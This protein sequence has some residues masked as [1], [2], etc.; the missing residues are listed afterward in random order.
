MRGASCRSRRAPSPRS[1]ARVS[2]ARCGS[3]SPTTTPSLPRRHPDPLL[4]RPSAGGDLGRLRE[5]GR[6]RRAQVHAGALDLALVTDDEGLRELRTDPRGAVALDRLAAL[7]VPEGEPIPLALG[8]PACIWRRVAEEALGAGG[9]VAACSSRRTTPRSLTVVRAGLAA[10]VLPVS[11]IGEG[12]RVLGPAGACRPCR[13]PHG[14]HLRARRARQRRLVRS[15]KR[16]GRRSAKCAGR[17]EGGGGS[18]RS[19]RKSVASGTI[20]AQHKGR[21]TERLRRRGVHSP[22]CRLS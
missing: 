19:T 21:W 17:R 13:S 12:L 5:F 20:V 3:A 7:Q 16:C 9:N 18:S 10:T 15:R 14:P 2:G 11:M 8:S 6:A 4:S 22:R 1:R